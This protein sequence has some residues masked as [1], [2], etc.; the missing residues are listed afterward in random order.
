MS[1]PRPYLETRM[2]F[3]LS[4]YLWIILIFLLAHIHCLIKE[5]LQFR[6]SLTEKH[7]F[8]T[9]IRNKPICF[10]NRMG[11]DMPKHHWNKL[12]RLKNF[13]VTSVKYWDIISEDPYDSN[14]LLH[15]TATK[16]HAHLHFTCRRNHAQ[17]TEESAHINIDASFDDIMVWFYNCCPNTLINKGNLHFII[18]IWEYYHDT[19]DH[20]EL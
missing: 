8:R 9:Q 12:M 16:N 13:Q 15:L 11:P 6:T 3:G 7:N 17:S 19:L 18:S 14:D 20:T 5:D 2:I 1:Y 4:K 10:K